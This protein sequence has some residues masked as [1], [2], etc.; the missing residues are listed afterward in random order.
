M[1]VTLASRWPWRDLGQLGGQS[2]RRQSSLTQH[3]PSTW[4]IAALYAFLAMKGN[5]NRAPDVGSPGLAPGGGVDDLSAAAP[6]RP[7][8]TSITHGCWG[9]SQSHLLAKRGHL[10]WVVEREDGSQVGERGW[11]RC[12]PARAFLMAT[13]VSLLEMAKSDCF[14]MLARRR[15]N[16]QKVGDSPYLFSPILLTFGIRKAVG[17][18]SGQ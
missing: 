12:R 14:Q 4:Q 7:W 2:N 13:S 6:A 8:E 11:K 3:L 5:E 15:I 17:K 16:S 10:S 18:S 1:F 9:D